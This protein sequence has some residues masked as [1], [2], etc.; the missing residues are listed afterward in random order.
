MLRR[1]CRGKAEEVRTGGRERVVRLVGEEE[2]SHESEWAAISSIAG[3]IGCS[4]ETLRKWVRQAERDSGKREGLSTEDRERM[5]ELR[6]GRVW[7]SRS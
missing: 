4:P 7:G 2:K 1:W 3:K 6:A 5:K